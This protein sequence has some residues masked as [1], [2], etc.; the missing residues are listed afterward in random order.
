MKKLIKKVIRFA[1]MKHD[2]QESWLDNI[3]DSQVVKFCEQNFFLNEKID[4]STLIRH[5]DPQGI[6]YAFTLQAKTGETIY[7]FNEYAASKFEAATDDAKFDEVAED[8]I[9]LVSESNCRKVI[10]GEIY[11]DQVVK[12]LRQIFGNRCKE[13][14][15]FIL[16]VELAKNNNLF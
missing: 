14:N 6:T 4:G 15:D 1:D 3:K 9:V 11:N 13:V 7:V 2:K 16:I 10:D 8:W 12:I 5:C